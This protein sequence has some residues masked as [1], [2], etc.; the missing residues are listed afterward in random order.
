VNKPNGTACDDGDVCSTASACQ[1]G[2]CVATAGGSDQ[3][4]DGV[5]DSTDNCPTVHNP[6]QADGDGDGVGDACVSVCVTIQRGV[7][8]D[9]HDAFLSGDYPTWATGPYFGSWTGLSSDGNIN[10]ALWKF[11]LSPIPAGATVTSATFSVY[12]LW[13]ADYNLITVH[14]VLV[15]WSEATVSLSSFGG[16][17]GWDF[18]SIGSFLGGGTGYR[19]I[20]LTGPVGEWVSG[21][22]PNN[23]V[24][25]DEPP[26]KRH[27]FYTG[28]GSSMESRAKL[29][30]CYLVGAAIGSQDNPADSCQHILTTNPQAA[31]GV[32]WL[33]PAAG[34]AAFQAYCD[35][36]TD[37]GGFTL[38]LKTDASSADHAT[39]DG[40]NEGALLSPAL[41]DVA[42]LSDTAISA[43]LLASGDDGEV[44]VTTPD[45]T[46]KLFVRDAGWSMTSYAGYPTA[47]E[48]KSSA[49]A[50]YSAGSQC[51]DGAGS[52][53]PDG[54]C[55]GTATAERACLRHDGASG[56]WLEGGSFT[57]AASHAALVWVR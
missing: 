42:K 6:T 18:T 33:E 26:V 51:Y 48:A 27:Y 15:P 23:G 19:Q 39:A 28:E 46:T 41:D 17:A 4:G 9:V 32:Y 53:P 44:R 10:R 20:D 36:T 54:Y 5:C 55:F 14:K 37:G 56:I 50:P 31:S 45:F 8:G 49:A 38:V 3:D 24:L 7:L 25:F 35:M 2:A 52:C 11:D 1:A 21:A 40:V 47:I 22:T 34:I 43:L 30:V 29:D 13:S 12:A 57:P 16:P